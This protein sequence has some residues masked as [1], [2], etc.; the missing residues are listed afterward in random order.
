MNAPERIG[1]AQ[2]RAISIVI[3]LVVAAF[4]Q[5][6]ASE[7]RPEGFLGALQEGMAFLYLLPYVF[8]AALGSNAHNP[9]A[10]VFFVVL[11]AEIYFAIRLVL[12]IPRAIRKASNEA[13]QPSKE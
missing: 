2:S 8:G 10:T 5:W 1:I 11:A 13:S 12:L 7:F 4:L 9:N 6:V 3:A